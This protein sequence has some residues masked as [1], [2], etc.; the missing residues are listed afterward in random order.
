MS[1]NIK[2]YFTA[3]ALCYHSCGMEVIVEDGKVVQVSG[4]KSHPLNKGELCPKGE[5]AIEHLYHPDRLKYPLKKVKG[6]W[7]RITWEQAVSEIS[8]KL[9]DLKTKYG[10]SILGSKPPSARRTISP[11][12][13]SAIG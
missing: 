2:T 9:S 4:Q 13:V 1:N 5:A 12:K 6:H 10:P 11:W 7:Q 3:C 8:S